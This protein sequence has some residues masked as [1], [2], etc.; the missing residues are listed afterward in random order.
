MI[1]DLNLC[2]EEAEVGCLLVEVVGMLDMLLL[3][4]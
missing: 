4:A 1:A 3:Y 2:D